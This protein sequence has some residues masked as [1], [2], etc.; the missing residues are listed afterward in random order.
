MLD[1][2]GILPALNWFCREYEKT[3]SPLSVQKQIG[4]SEDE[5]PDLLKT[6][7]FRISQEALSNIARHSKASLVDLA[8][9]KD[10]GR[11]ELTI[12]D[13]GHGFRPDESAKGF[14]L[15]TMRERAELSGG[16]FEIHAA[17]GKGTRIRASWPLTL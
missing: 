14:G 15:S 8:L 6:V 12:Q 3:Y 9:Q 13:N 10:G 4:I 2:L 5:V 7:I 1:D 11:L 16:I 17:E